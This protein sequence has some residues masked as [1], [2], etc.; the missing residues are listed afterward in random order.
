MVECGEFT[1]KYRALKLLYSA[2]DVERKVIFV[3]HD[4]P[5]GE[6]TAK[7]DP[8]RYIFGLILRAE[9]RWIC[10][11]P[12]GLQVGVRTYM[13]CPK[14]CHVYYPLHNDVWCPQ[15]CPRLLSVCK[16]AW[17]GLWGSVWFVQNLHGLT[18]EHCGHTYINASVIWCHDFDKA[19]VDIS[20]GH[21]QRVNCMAMN[22]KCIHL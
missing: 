21:L 6:T 12:C 19:E 18:N 9:I 1:I 5:Q 22:V 3:M 14:C 17:P 10:L 7:N 15:P 16:H 20:C 8:Y 11:R 13:L 2:L 4:Q